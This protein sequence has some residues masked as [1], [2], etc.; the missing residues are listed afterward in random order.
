MKIG[1]EWS[2]FPQNS[3]SMMLVSKEVNSECAAI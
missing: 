3:N 2:T 1:D